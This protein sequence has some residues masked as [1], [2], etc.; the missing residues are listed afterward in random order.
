MTNK[1]IA[2]ARLK[3]ALKKAKTPKL[4]A[5][6]RDIAASM[7]GIHYF[8]HQS[9]DGYEY[10]GY[11]FDP[12]FLNFKEIHDKPRKGWEVCLDVPDDVVMFRRKFLVV[13]K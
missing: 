7:N 3:A 4:R 11:R 13:V 12:E 9:D 8:F 2:D 1:I 6:I 10:Q 5:A